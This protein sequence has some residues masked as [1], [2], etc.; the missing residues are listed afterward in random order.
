MG[1][2]F[3]FPDHLL[4]PGMKNEMIAELQKTPIPGMRKKQTL[5]EWGKLT[6]TQITAADIY[7][8]YPERGN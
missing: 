3:E 7:A 8:V 6:K 1:F 4:Q 5:F 2:I